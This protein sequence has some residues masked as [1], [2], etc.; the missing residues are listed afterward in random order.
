MSTS[1]PSQFTASLLTSGGDADVGRRIA[2]QIRLWREPEGRKLFFLGKTYG[3]S[4]GISIMSCFPK[5]H[6]FQTRDC[7]LLVHERK[8]KKG[9]HLDG[10]LPACLSVVNELLAPIESGQ[11][12]EKEG[13]EQL[14]EGLSLSA[15]KLMDKVYCKDWYQKADKALQL[16]LVHRLI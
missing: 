5:S 11:R 14:V 1:N 6:R 2:Q 7:E 3:Y 15:Q 10:A 12:L 4:A 13:F 16:G 8:L 9:V